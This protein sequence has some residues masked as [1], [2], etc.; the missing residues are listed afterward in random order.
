MVQS[1][2]DGSKTSAEVEDHF[3]VHSPLSADFKQ[4]DKE[5]QD[6][7]QWVWPYV[8]RREGLM[9]TAAPEVE[10]WLLI[11]KDVHDTEVNNV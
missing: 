9:S 4:C 7:H 6:R 11:I 1:G 2:D 10:N 8:T 3:V 5:Q